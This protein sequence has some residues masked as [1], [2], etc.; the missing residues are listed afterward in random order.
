MDSPSGGLAPGVRS[1]AV[2]CTGADDDAD[3][4][5]DAGE[6]M[7]DVCFEDK[8]KTEFFALQCGHF[9]CTDCWKTHLQ[10]SLSEKGVSVVAETLCP[11]APTCSWRVDELAW[12]QLA[13]PEVADKYQRMLIRSFIDLHPDVKWCPN[14]KGCDRGTLLN[15]P[16]SAG[17]APVLTCLCRPCAHQQRCDTPA[18]AGP[19]RAHAATRFAFRA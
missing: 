6:E 4:K 12:K 5:T 16:V 10:T 7:C 2:D 11:A 3:G 1:M 15:Q 9:F 14:P 17:C 13:P 8:P 19:S 18:S